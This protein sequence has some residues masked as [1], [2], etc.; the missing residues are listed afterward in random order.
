MFSLYFRTFYL[1]LSKN[2]LICIGYA[3]LTWR[4]ILLPA[5]L[6]AVIGPSGSSAITVTLVDANIIY[7]RLFCLISHI[8]WYFI[9]APITCF[10]EFAELLLMAEESRSR[11]K[12]TKAN[13]R[14]KT[15]GKVENPEYLG[16]NQPYRPS[17]RSF[18]TCT[19]TCIFSLIHEYLY[20]RSL[21]PTYPKKQQGIFENNN[22]GE[23]RFLAGVTTSRA[24][25]G[26]RRKERNTSGQR[27]NKFNTS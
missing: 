23:N 6:C 7:L 11:M 2:L 25:S 15:K 24:T 19:G 10:L 8:S 14:N 27:G 16:G 3:I 20:E 4:I 1:R 26:E 21:G 22:G 18:H 12:P 9:S 17:Y 13:Q 5:F